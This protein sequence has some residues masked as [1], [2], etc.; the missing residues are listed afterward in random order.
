MSK[1]YKK[2]KP[3]FSILSICFNITNSLRKKKKK[4]C[5]N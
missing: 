2:T 5:Q 3:N 4:L 1:E